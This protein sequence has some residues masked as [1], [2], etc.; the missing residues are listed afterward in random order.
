M[1]LALIVLAAGSS[2]RFGASDKLTANLSGEPLLAVTL[3]K[4]AAS[5]FATRYVVVDPDNAAVKKIASQQNFTIV[6]NR[7]TSD[8]LGSSIAAGIRAIESKNFDGVAI[9]LGDMPFVSAKTIQALVEKFQSTPHG[10]I[11]TPTHGDQRGHPVIF[12]SQHFDELCNLSGDAGAREIIERNIEYLTTVPVE[13]RG[14]NRDVDRPGDL[15]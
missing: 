11:I 4:Y 1:R 14:I 13:D 12:P 5:S 10:S 7:H 2:K 6:E 9:A 15:Y 3:K 8:G